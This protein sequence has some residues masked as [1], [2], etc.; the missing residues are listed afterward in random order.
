VLWDGIGRGR[1][2]ADLQA[3]KAAAADLAREYAG[4]VIRMQLYSA[5]CIS[6]L[7]TMKKYDFQKL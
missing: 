5:R 7:S 2:A 6:G 4:E 3:P 1:R